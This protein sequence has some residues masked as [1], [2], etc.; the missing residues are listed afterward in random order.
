MLVSWHQLVLRS[1]FLH[2][3]PVIRQFSPYQEAGS[4]SGGENDGPM[5][6][7]IVEDDEKTAVT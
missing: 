2:K 7:L 5:R 3:Y 1:S 4:S 6:I